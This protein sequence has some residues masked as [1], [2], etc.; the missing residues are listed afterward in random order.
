[1]PELILR[2]FAENKD[3]STAGYAKRHNEQFNGKSSK[4]EK[5]IESVVKID[6]F[7]YLIKRCSAGFMV[8]SH[9]FSFVM[10]QKN[11]VQL[12]QMCKKLKRDAVYI[13]TKRKKSKRDLQTGR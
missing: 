6:Q 13:L 10:S 2:N 4:L 1:M 8:H 5:F 7:E 9:A 11:L 12:R 3:I